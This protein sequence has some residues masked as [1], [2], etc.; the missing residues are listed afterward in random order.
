M[1]YYFCEYW[2]ELPYKWLWQTENRIS[3]KFYEAHQWQKQLVHSNPIQPYRQETKR[4]KKSSAEKDLEVLGKKAEWSQQCVPVE[5]KSTS[6]LLSKQD[7]GQQVNG[8]DSFHPPLSCETTL[9]T[10]PSSELPKMSKN[11]TYW[12]NSKAVMVL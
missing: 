7:C 9:S 1:C 10:V 4:L 11:L 2:L 5:T 3:Q 12:G 6:I 8:C